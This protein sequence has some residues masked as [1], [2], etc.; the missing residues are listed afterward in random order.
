MRAVWFAF[1]A[2]VFALPGLAVAQNLLPPIAP[3][4]G[5]GPGLPGGMEVSRPLTVIEIPATPLP[6][7]EPEAQPKPDPVQRVEEV[8]QQK[9][10]RRGPLG[11]AWDD[12]S[13]LLWWPRA[14]PLPP[15][16]TAT[17][18]GA[19]PVLGGRRTLLVVGNRGISDQDIAGGRFTL[20]AS[21]NERETVGV[22][23][24]YFF[25]G[26]RTLKT[27]TNNV[28]NWPVPAV[29]L[30]F[31]NAITGQPDVFLTAAP[32]M[33][34]GLVSATTTTRAQG[35]E[36]NALMNLLDD[37]GVKLNAL[38]GYR[39]L[40]VNEG[41]TV[42]QLRYTASNFGPIYDQF[43]GHNRFNGGQ[44][45]LH[46]DL[47]HNLLFCELTGK[48]AFGQTFEVVKIDGSTTLH[49]PVLGGLVSQSYLGG[50]YAL[51]SNIGRYTRSAFA[52]VP[53]GIFKIGLKFSDVGRF[54]VGYNFLYLS[55][56]M[57]PGEQI[58]HTL[59]PAQIPALNPAGAGSFALGDR[60]RPLLS[61]TD[62]WMQGLL[63]GLETRY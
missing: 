42:D 5:D 45:G 6:A 2:V 10:T 22:E 8:Q 16:V 23:A 55:D 57:R 43:D 28:G 1:A 49:T 30:P 25:L 33:A 44:L 54:Y 37:K 3:G 59:N 7:A 53:E 12:L 63:I 31:V 27:T 56:L 40:Q 11:P 39:F 13:F 62:F 15:L 35:A 41:V 17:P 50:V 58:D 24:V 52:V 38:V 9:Q 48:I 29:G 26:T 60:P 32:G 18:T 20:G 21:V 36:A 4:P 34:N 47:S 61:H 14:A 51:P 46:A 19:P